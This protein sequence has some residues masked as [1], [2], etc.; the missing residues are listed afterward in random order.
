MFASKTLDD[1]KPLQVGT[2]QD[3]RIERES[4]AA[5]NSHRSLDDIREGPRMQPISFYRRRMSSDLRLRSLPF[6]REDST[7]PPFSLTAT[8]M[9]WSRS[10]MN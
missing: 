1:C 10:P 4:A 8:A 7:C 5:A 2:G 6:P 3:D 9:P